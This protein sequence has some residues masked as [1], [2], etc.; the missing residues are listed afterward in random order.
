M[1]VSAVYNRNVHRAWRRVARYRPVA[2]SG[3]SQAHHPEATR[4]GCVPEQ[5]QASP[6]QSVAAGRFA[7]YTRMPLQFAHHVASGSLR[8]D[9]QQHSGLLDLV[10]C[11]V[12]FIRQLCD[13]P[14]LLICQTHDIF[15]T[16][17]ST[18]A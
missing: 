15:S 3:A 10:R 14:T 9:L 4:A 12:A 13:L 6:P 7:R 11:C 17:W 5:P 18:L 2:G 1:T 8:I 16:H